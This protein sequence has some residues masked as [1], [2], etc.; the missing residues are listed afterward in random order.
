MSNNV[1]HEQIKLARKSDLYA[2]LIKYHNC[3]FT[4][5]GVTS[6]QKITTA[7]PSGKDIAVTRTS[8]TM[9]PATRLNI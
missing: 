3:I 5:E 2:F 6:V 1:S 8:L 7:F 9:K 4:H